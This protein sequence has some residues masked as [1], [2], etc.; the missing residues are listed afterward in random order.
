MLPA[1]AYTLTLAGANEDLD[2]TGDLDVRQNVI[3]SGTGATRL[4]S[5]TARGSLTLTNLSTLTSQNS[6][7]YTKQ[8]LP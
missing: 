2:A 6:K 5:V 3:I 7:S 1:G 8:I 4:F